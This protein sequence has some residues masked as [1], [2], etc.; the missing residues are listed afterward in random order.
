MHGQVIPEVLH[1]YQVFRQAER[2]DIIHNHAGYSTCAFASLVDTPVLMTLHGIFT[3]ENKAYFWAFRNTLFYSAISESQRMEFPKLNYVD[4]IYNGI[5]LKDYPY[6]ADKEDYL[7]SLGRISSLKGNHIAIAAA[8]RS[9]CDLIMAGKVDKKDRE[10]FDEM[11]KPHLN[12]QYITYIGEVS[13][14]EKMKLLQKA[15][16]LLFPIKWPE[17][18]GLVMIEAMACGT[19]VI[20]FRKG[21]VSEIVAEKETG[22]IVESLEGIIEAV[23]RLDEIKPINCRKHIEDKFDVKI[24]ADRYEQA[25]YEII[26]RCRS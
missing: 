4:T 19:P 21:S 14:E 6:C 15:R 7:L 9:G 16:C 24:M 25:Y 12:D 3:E 8:Q 18:F 2:F 17:P 10:Y 22:F 23:E 11:V 5:D 20:A 13:L 26:D 1:L